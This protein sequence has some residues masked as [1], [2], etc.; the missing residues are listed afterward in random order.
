[1][2][3]FWLSFAAFAAL[4]ACSGGNPFEAT[5]TNTDDPETGIPTEVAGNLT[6]VTYN[7]V[8][9]T[10]TVKG[11][12]FDNTPIDAVYTKAPASMDVGDYEAYI[13][14][15]GSLDRHTTV[16]VKD[17]GGT[18]A[19]V[20]VTGGQ[21]ESY[22]GGVTYGRAGAY[23]PPATNTSNSG[24]VTYAGDYVG[25]L[26]GPGDG[27][28][29]LPITPDNG[30]T[31]PFPV[32]A[33]EVTGRVVINADFAQNT[34]AGLVY[35]RE[36]VDG[37]AIGVGPPI[38][39]LALDPA[40]IDPATGTFQGQVSQLNQSRGVYGGIFG[41]TDASAIAGGLFA[42]DHIANVT[43]EEEYGIFVLTQCGQ[44]GADAL[45]NQPVP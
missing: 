2:K 40:A 17:I 42:K 13:Y 18:R 29:L 36:Y 12:A 41:G 27:G 30:N 45:C 16:Y 20:A 15:D 10:L 33:G 6:S 35:D 8:A 14:Q 37:A 39:N 3:R 5:T 34:V 23:N 19:A 9:Q 1:M 4:S 43:G 25:L 11:I 32:E 38:D 26:N 44:P 24:L 22:F 31:D 21:F 28:S 7:P